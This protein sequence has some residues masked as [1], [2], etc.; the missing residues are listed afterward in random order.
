M[1]NT[2]N[3]YLSKIGL[4]GFLIGI[5]LMVVLAY[6]FPSLGI[7]NNP[8]KNK[9]QTITESEKLICHYLDKIEYWEQNRFISEKDSLGYFNDKLENYLINFLCSNDSTINYP[10]DSAQSHRLYVLTSKD[11]NFRIYNWNTLEG[12][13]MQSFRTIFQIKNSNSVKVYPIKYTDE[14]N[15]DCYLDINEVSINNKNYYLLTNVNISSSAIYYFQINAQTISEDL[16]IIDA[17]I[18][19]TDSNNIS[20]IGY[21]IDLASQWNRKNEKARDWMKLEYDKNIQM[22]IMPYFDEN[23]KITSRKIK[24]I[25]NGKEFVKK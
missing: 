11:K 14:D 8:I 9:I 7:A 4:D 13:T 25:F 18:I 10:F 12:G 6:F 23:D 15:G 17:P 22:I 5:M 19:K 16:K 2:L 1:L 3:K 20:N 21:G 24:Y